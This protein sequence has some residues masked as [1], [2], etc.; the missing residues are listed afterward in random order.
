[1]DETF[2]IKL[3]KQFGKR[4]QY[5]NIIEVFLSKQCEV[6]VV[7][8]SVIIIE[9]RKENENVLEEPIVRRLTKF[10]NMLANSGSNNLL[11]V[12]KLPISEELIKVSFFNI[13]C[14][15]KPIFT[16]IFRTGTKLFEIL[17]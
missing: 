17:L 12:E 2:W 7:S 3:H 5:I 10:D 16:S 1:M 14:I 11:V 4:T 13:L 9:P 6:N 8:N 15:L